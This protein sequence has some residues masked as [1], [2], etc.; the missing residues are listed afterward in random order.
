MKTATPFLPGIPTKLDGRT[1][2]SQLEAIRE[3]IKKLRGETIADLGILFSDILPVELLHEAQNDIRSRVFPEVITFWAW[4]SQL[5]ES[6]ASCAKALTLVQNWY[7]SASLPSPAFD[8]SAF[9]RAR[10]RLSYRFLDVVE[11]HSLSYSEARIEPHHLWYGHRL[12]AIDGTSVKLLDTP[13]NQMEY[14]QPSN[15]KPGCG[16]PVMGVTGVLDLATGRIEKHA[17]GNFREH[18]AKG[19]YNLCGHFGQDDLL[20]ADRAYASY[21]LM[22]LL[23]A[24]GTQSVMRLHQKREGKLDW[25]RGRRIDADSR[26]VTWTKPPKPG[27][28]GITEE[29]WAALPNTMEVRL[30]RTKGTGRDGK[31]RTLYI[32]TTL[33]DAEAYPTEEIALLYAERWKIEVKFRDIKTTMKLEVLRV[34]SPKMAHKSMRMACNC[35]NLVKALQLEAVRGEPVVMDEIG[36][37]GTLDVVNEFRSQFRRLQNKPRLL[38]ARMVALTKRILERIFRIR[39]GRSEPRATKLRPKPYQY[40]TKPRSEFREIQHRNHYRAA[41]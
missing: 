14:P 34:K 38:A 30:V 2:R 32:A 4:I 1:R 16:Y 15:Q 23:L 24:G 3:K 41:A 36:F 28:S 22:G 25:R 27:S 37:K 17:V 6:N 21:E 10:G 9:C 12:K 7:D 39:P 13:A 29:E 40:L 5:L 19:L 35:Y 31:E 8:T 20:I 33:I 26:L 18:D 11:A